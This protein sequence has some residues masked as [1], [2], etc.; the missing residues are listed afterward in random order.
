MHR[1][2]VVLRAAF[3][4]ALSLAMLVPGT[5]FASPKASGPTLSLSSGAASASTSGG[6]S[7]GSDVL[8]NS[9]K[10]DP[11]KQAVLY[12]GQWEP[13]SQFSGWAY[14]YYLGL[15]PDANGNVSMSETQNNAGTFRY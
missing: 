9:T 13:N 4:A 15:W 2:T 3:L 6:I 7:V 8:I 1:R 12:K 10:L 5:A 11:S 14:V